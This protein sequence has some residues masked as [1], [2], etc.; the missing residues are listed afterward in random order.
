MLTVILFLSPFGKTENS[1]GKR[2]V[3]ICLNE[4]AA[5]DSTRYARF[6]KR[7]EEDATENERAHSVGATEVSSRGG[8]NCD[9]EVSGLVCFVSFTAFLFEPA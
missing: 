1:R 7:Q 5:N 3:G 8:R 6:R 4:Y 9:A 2:L